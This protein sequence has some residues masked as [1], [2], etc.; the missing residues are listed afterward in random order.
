MSSMLLI[1]M[2][3]GGGSFLYQIV[4]NIHEQNMKKLEIKNQEAKNE[5]DRI[6]L[7][8]DL[9]P[10]YLSIEDKVLNGLIEEGVRYEPSSRVEQRIL[11]DLRES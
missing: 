8:K 3:F 11:D 7:L 6:K 1:F 10:K 4:E 9:G 2:L 5:A